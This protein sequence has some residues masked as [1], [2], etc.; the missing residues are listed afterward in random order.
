[1]RFK[2]AIYFSGKLLETREF[3]KDIVTLGRSPKCD[4]IIDNLGVSRVHSQ[5]ERNGDVFILRDMKSNNGTFVHC[6]KIQRYH[7]I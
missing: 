2:L 1:M 7:F 5:I 4:I 6:E 3:D